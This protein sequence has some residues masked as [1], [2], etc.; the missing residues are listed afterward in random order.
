MKPLESS[1]LVDSTKLFGLIFQIL[2]DKLNPIDDTTPIDT[3][4]V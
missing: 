4:T 1:H 2:L 3:Q